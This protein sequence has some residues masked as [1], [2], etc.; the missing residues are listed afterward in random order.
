MSNTTTSHSEAPLRFCL[1]G[2]IAIFHIHN[3]SLPPL[4]RLIPFPFSPSVR[5]RCKRDL[6]QFDSPSPILVTLIDP[7]STFIIL[8]K[9]LC[10][11]RRSP[12]ILCARDK[13]EL[14]FRFGQSSSHWSILA[15]SM[16]FTSSGAL[17][18]WMGFETVAVRWGRGG[19]DGIVPSGPC[20][21]LCY[22][23]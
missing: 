9:N 22:C 13:P 12:R 17:L 1:G 21:R 23:R 4:P 7:Q 19:N 11:A 8:L 18:D 14:W 6:L 5:K 15:S 2:S 10:V 20:R 16:T 3:K